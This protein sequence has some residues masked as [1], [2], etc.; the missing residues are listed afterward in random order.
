[1][2]GNVWKRWNWLE[3]GLVP[4]AAAAVRVAWITPLVRLVL[5]NVLVAPM[6]TVYPSWLILGLLIGASL[7]RHVRRSA[8][9]GG[10]S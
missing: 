2:F 7:L 10:G 6:G 9:A 3:G 8:V 5:N 4:L 1:M